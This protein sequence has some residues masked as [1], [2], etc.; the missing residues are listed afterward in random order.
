M[1]AKE[2]RHFSRGLSLRAA[3][4]RWIDTLTASFHCE[5]GVLNASWSL[6]ADLSSVPKARRLTRTRLAA[7]GLE[8]VGDVVELLVSELVTNALRHTSG[9]CR[10]SLTAEDGLLR[11]EIEDTSTDQPRLRSDRALIEDGR[12]LHFLA[13]LACCWGSSRTQVGKVVWFEVPTRAVA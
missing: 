7:W 2:T 13:A 3:T 10:L 12:G 8:K 1:F 6:P 4:V 5:P 11:C 9:P